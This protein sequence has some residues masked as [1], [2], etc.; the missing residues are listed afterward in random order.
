MMRW[1]ELK[2][3][4]RTNYW[5]LLVVECFFYSQYFL[6]SP[7]TSIL[8]VYFLGVVGYALRW[9]IILGLW[10]E[11]STLPLHNSSKCRMNHDNQSQTDHK[12]KLSGGIINVR[13]TRKSIT[14]LLM[15]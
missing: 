3:F 4:V 9:F 11:P 14:K 2:A 7:K 5:E 15:S 12:S 10:R 13:Q 8:G 1:H 6:A